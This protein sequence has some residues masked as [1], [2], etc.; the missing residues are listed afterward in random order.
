MFS[1]LGGR[2]VVPRL[3]NFTCRR[4][5]TLWSIFIGSVYMTYEDG[6]LCSETSIH[7][8]QTPV[9][10]PKER[11]QNHTCLK[12]K[13]SWT[14]LLYVTLYMLIKTWFWVPNGK[15]CLIILFPFCKPRHGPIYLLFFSSNLIQRTHPVIADP[16][17]RAVWGVGLRPL[18]CWDCGFD[19]NRGHGC[20]SVVCV[21]CCQVQVSSTSWSLVQ[22]SPTDCGRSLCVIWKP[23]EWGGPGP[24]EG[25]RVKKTNKQTNT[26][27]SKCRTNSA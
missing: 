24:T 14:Q 6:T 27:W 20:L 12:R 23:R 8:I 7:K 1:F 15:L 4:F 10:H 17:G 25:C 16:S 11:T 13:G 21:V 9:N 3:L 5:G 22:R 18:A 2:G 19:S 26:Q